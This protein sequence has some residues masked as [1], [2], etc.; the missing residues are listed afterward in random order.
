M[1]EEFKDVQAVAEGL[2]VK[3]SGQKR[4]NDMV[5]CP[6]LQSESEDCLLMYAFATVLEM[7]IFKDSTF[8]NPYDWPQSQIIG[9][10]ETALGLSDTVTR[11]CCCQKVEP[12]IAFDDYVTTLTGKEAKDLF[13][14]DRVYF[15]DLPFKQAYKEKYA[16]GLGMVL[17]KK[18]R[19]DMFLKFCFTENGVKEKAQYVR[20]LKGKIW[21]EDGCSKK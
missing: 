6:V 14:V 1:P 4:G 13:N 2:V 11:P 12:L 3:V 7:I 18:D 16:Y 9:E 10:L 15:Y 20:M 8:D 5:Y 19:P 21:Y 17:A